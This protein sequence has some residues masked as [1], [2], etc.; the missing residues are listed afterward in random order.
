MPKKAIKLE[1]EDENGAKY[2][3]KVEGNIE[4]NKVLRLL[5]LY[6]LL[7]SSDNVKNNETENNI[8]KDL[9]ST[10]KFI[11]KDLP[12]TGFT[13]KEIQNVLED[14]YKISVKLPIISTYLRRM[15]DKGELSRKKVKR[16]WVY[17]YKEIEKIVLKD[18]KAKN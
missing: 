3:F 12:L 11:I 8:E 4:K 7:S 18:K 2:S 5:E 6:D 1:F 13:S 15:Y 16:E 17:F 14:R 10:I 9:Y